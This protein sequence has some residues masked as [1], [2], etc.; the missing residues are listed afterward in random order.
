MLHSCILTEYEQ[1]YSV[2]NQ[3]EMPNITPQL[4]QWCGGCLNWNTNKFGTD[5][6]HGHV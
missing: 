3:S 6:E 1:N 5:A 4:L 2:E